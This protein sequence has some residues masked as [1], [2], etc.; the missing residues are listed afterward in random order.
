MVVVAEEPVAYTAFDDSI[1]AAAVVL[2][3]ELAAVLAFV[4]VVVLA[5]AVA[6]VAE[7]RTC[8]TKEVGMDSV[9]FYYVQSHDEIPKL[10]LEKATH[11]QIFLAQRADVDLVCFVYCAHP[12]ACWEQVAVLDGAVEVRMLLS[13]NSPMA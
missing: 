5:A 1:L 8:D 11:I 12:L 3:F 7:S 2:A 4:P 9:P 13:A 6:V 10:L